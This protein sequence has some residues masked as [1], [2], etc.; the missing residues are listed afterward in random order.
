MATDDAGTLSSSGA[1]ERPAASGEG[2]AGSDGEQDHRDL[3]VQLLDVLKQDGAAVDSGKLKVD[4]LVTQRKELQKE[5]KRLT[6][7]LRNENRKRVRIRRRSQYLSNED[8]VDVLAMRKCKT[9]A[10]ET[11]SKAKS[12]GDQDAP[13]KGRKTKPQEPLASSH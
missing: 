1:A 5:R 12:S 7:A 13:K 2:G 6:A 9:N 10:A 11:K 8:L 4:E 3:A